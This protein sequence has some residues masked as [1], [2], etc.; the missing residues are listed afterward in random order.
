M[1]LNNECEVLDD[2]NGEERQALRAIQHV[3]D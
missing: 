3:G 1:I 2:P